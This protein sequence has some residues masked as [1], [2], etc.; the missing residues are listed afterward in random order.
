MQGKVPGPGRQV[1]ISDSIELCIV[2]LTRVDC[3]YMLRIRSYA[4]FL[5]QST[6]QA[7]LLKRKIMITMHIRM[8]TMYVCTIYWSVHIIW[9]KYCKYGNFHEN[10]IFGN[11]AKGHF[12]NFSNSQ[13]GHE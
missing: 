10:F 11:C 7:L 8:H 3:T 2:E 5:L 9:T 4:F 1:E 13:Q 6:R 12:C